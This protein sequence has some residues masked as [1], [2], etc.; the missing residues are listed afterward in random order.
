MKSD[1]Y[2]TLLDFMIAP[3]GVFP[4]VCALA[5]VRSLPKRTVRQGNSPLRCIEWVSSTNIFATAARFSDEERNVAILK[6]IYR[7]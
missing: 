4:S 6:K 2:A 5:S 7:M 3:P 1:A